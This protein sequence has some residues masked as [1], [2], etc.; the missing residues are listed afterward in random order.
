M[1]IGISSDRDD[2]V[3]RE[4]TAENKMISTQYRDKDR[5]ILRAFEIRSFPTYVIIDHE[6]IVRHRSSGMSWS[7]AAS[8]DNE[9]RK[10]IKI[11]AKSAESQ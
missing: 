9:I 1:L 10:Q 4:F 6:G 2:Q 3:W 5:R 8:L 7:R 11:I